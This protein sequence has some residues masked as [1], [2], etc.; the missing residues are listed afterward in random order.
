MN[1]SPLT[2]DRLCDELRPQVDHRLIRDAYLVGQRD[3][4][5]ELGEAG[6]LTLSARQGRS[7]IVLT[8]ATTDADPKR[9]PWVD[10]YVR[11]AGILSIDH[12]PYERIVHLTLRKRDRIG[13]TTDTRI[14][15]EL[16]GRHANIILVDIKTEKILGALR[17]VNARKNRVREVRPGKIYQP[18]PQL[19]RTT[20]EEIDATHLS[21]LPDTPLDTRPYAL[22][23]H[24]VGLDE[25]VAQEVL[26][27]NGLAKKSVIV[28]ED[29]EN[30]A[31]TIRSFFHSP[32]FRSG[33]ARIQAVDN[34]P[35]V[36]VLELKHTQPDR[37]FAN[38]SEAILDVAASEEIVQ[39]LKGHQKN[40]EKDLKNQ[41][42]IINRKKERIQAD[43]EDAANA[44]QY[45]KMGNLLMSNLVQIPPHAESITLPDLFGTTNPDVV[46]PLN[47]E[48]SAT[49]NASEY[50][51][52]ARKARKGAPILATRLEATKKEKNQIQ[53]HINRLETIQSEAELNDLRRELETARLVKLPKK[54]PQKNSRRKKS[55]I[56]PRRYRTHEGWLVLVGRNNTEN[57]RLTKSSTREDIFFHAHGCPGS[58]VIL[59][60]EGRADHPSRSTLKEAASLAAYWS[61]ARGSKSVSVNYTDIRYVQKPRGAPAGLV[62]IRNEKTIMVEPR[63]LKRED[64]I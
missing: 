58:H 28:Q 13:T 53:Q 40:L 33:G 56:H 60:R 19:S 27:L 3:L 38:L 61:K 35:M 20:P 57:D 18:P 2:L 1:L 52:R 10:R 54:R 42:K 41:L 14:I 25:L 6:Q 12:V 7:C 46:I 23:S 17:S 37:T 63:K 51:K 44:D 31:Q 48:R 55:D 43:I 50:L 5:F 11:G 30:L 9:L 15:C 45:K 34:R 8:Q 4:I 29:L 47:P 22:I 39:E 21:F 62:T 49:A 64:A 36:C 16:I 26:Y 24:V 32:P 59:K